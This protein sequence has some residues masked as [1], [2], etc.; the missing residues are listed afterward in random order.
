MKDL[1]KSVFS[2][3]DHHT[4]TSY[5]EESDTFGHRWIPG[6]EISASIEGRAIHL[7]GYSFAPRPTDQLRAA[8]QGI[9]AGYQQR[10]QSIYANIV[11]A[12]YHLPPLKEIRDEHLPLPIYNYDLATALAK[13]LQLSSP[14]EALQYA[15]EHGDLFTVGEGNFLPEAT[16]MIHMMRDSNLLV[17]FAH[18]GTRYLLDETPESAEQFTSLLHTLVSAGLGGLEVFYPQHRS[19]QKV[20]FLEFAHQLQL[21][22]T[23]GSDFHGPGRGIPSP[24]L[25]LPDEH[26]ERFLAA[27]P[28]VM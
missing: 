1:P 19:D 10:S 6:I 25:E 17:V 26:V 2:I 16:D 14:R 13:S 27:I 3:A 15:K 23:G 28:G 24:L 11:E 21:I 8:L 9:V 4:F 18:P 12:G 20:R 7:L 5:Q 22:P